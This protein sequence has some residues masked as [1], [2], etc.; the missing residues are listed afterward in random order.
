MHF[1]LVLYFVVMVNGSL[2]AHPAVSS[3]LLGEIWHWIQ[4]GATLTDVVHYLR[5][6][7]VSAGYNYYTWKPGIICVF[8]CPITIEYM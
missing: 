1:I 4:Q 5:Q 6:R 3:L 2:M 8:Y 7:T